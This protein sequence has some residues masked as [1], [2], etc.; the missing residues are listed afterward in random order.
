MRYTFHLK[1]VNEHNSFFG[2]DC[3]FQSTSR[4]HCHNIVQITSLKLLKFPG[5]PVR[6][7]CTMSIFINNTPDSI[8]FFSPL[9]SSS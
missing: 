1:D 8:N 7:V 4:Q 3:H 2:T 9:T 5:L 6:N